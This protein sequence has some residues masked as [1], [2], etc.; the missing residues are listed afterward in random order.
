MNAAQGA[1]CAGAL[2]RKRASRPAV[3]LPG[4]HGI[5]SDP[6]GLASRK[7]KVFALTGHLIGEPG[8]LSWTE[9]VLDILVYQLYRLNEL[10]CWEQRRKGMR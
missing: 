5:A 3:C 7:G 1:M 6:R 4:R 2:G 10:W 9:R 8:A